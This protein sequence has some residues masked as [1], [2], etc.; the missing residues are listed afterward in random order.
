MFAGSFI[1]ASFI[2]DKSFQKVNSETKMEKLQSAEIFLDFQFGNSF[3]LFTP[4]HLL[5]N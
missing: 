3:D 4:F 5:T 1:K 2:Y